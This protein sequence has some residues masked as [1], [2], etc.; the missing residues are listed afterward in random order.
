MLP[1]DTGVAYIVRE[2]KSLLQVRTAELE[3]EEPLPP[4]QLDAQT[5]AKPLYLVTLGHSWSPFPGHQTQIVWCSTTKISSRENTLFAKHTN[6]LKLPPTR[7][8]HQW[9]SRA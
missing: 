3:F 5:Q 8:F 1:S 6:K 4:I 2:E 7:L 9:I